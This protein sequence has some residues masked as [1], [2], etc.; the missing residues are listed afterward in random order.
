M[1]LQ[2][3]LRTYGGILDQF[4][5]INEYSLSKRL[6]I[7]KQ[8]IIKQLKQM[9]RDNILKYKGY[10]IVSKLSFLVPRE[11][12]F[13]INRIAQHIERRNLLKRSKAAA[14]IG[15]IR[16]DQIC[17]YAQILSYFDEDINNFSCGKCD[18]CT[19]KKDEKISYQSLADEILKL[20]KISENLNSKEIAEKLDSDK[21]S[22]L[23]TLQLLLDNETLLLNSQNKFFINR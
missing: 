6:Q 9:D 8:D 10:D 21:E 15:F 18:V 23:K 7:S 19:K 17:R 1:L 12:Q 14:V 20:F 5:R 22:I 11:D 13:T 3:L 16:N 2:N 4:I